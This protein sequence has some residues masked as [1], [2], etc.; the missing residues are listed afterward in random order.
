MCQRGPRPLAAHEVKQLADS[1]IASETVLYQKHSHCWRAC[2]YCRR[3][4]DSGQ[5]AAKRPH[6]QCLGPSISASV[7][8]FLNNA[9]SAAGGLAVDASF[10]ACEV[11]VMNKIYP[12]ENAAAEACAA[13]AAAAVDDDDAEDADADADD[14]AH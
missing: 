6:E 1:A 11:L 14:H 9:G 12:N 4:A 10:G 7:E 13:A 5:S 8:G 3:V 2:C